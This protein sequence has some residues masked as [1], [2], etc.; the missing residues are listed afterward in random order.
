[1]VDR[2]LEALGARFVSRGTRHVG[3]FLR[4]PV[5]WSWLVAA[6]AVPG[7]ALAV[8]LAVWFQAG[9]RKRRSDLPINLSRIGV[10][11][12]TAS[13]G[14]DALAKAGLVR[15]GRRPGRRPT[16]T[17]IRNITRRKP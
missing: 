12:S 6:M 11:R 3:L 4:G 14:L 5:P 1:M 16:V 9:L 17:I 10:D 13:R 15:I 2:R 7:R 8:G